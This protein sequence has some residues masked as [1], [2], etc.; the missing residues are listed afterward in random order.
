MVGRSV[1]SRRPARICEQVV[2]RSVQTSRPARILQANRGPEKRGSAHAITAPWA[3]PRRFHPRSC[4]GPGWKI[5]VS[6]RIGL[7]DTPAIHPFP[8]HSAAFFRRLAGCRTCTRRHPEIGC[9]LTGL[10]AREATHGGW[11]NARKS[12]SNFMPGRFRRS[13]R[14]PHVHGHDLG[15]GTRRPVVLWRTTQTEAGS[16]R[17]FERLL[18]R[19]APIQEHMPAARCAVH[20]CRWNTVGCLARPRAHTMGH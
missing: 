13:V 7:P 12:C 14:L 6:S 15:R 11:K 18:A 9:R 5:R 2:G 3:L 17:H 8:L 19:L 1:E 10:C 16:A 4:G 20:D